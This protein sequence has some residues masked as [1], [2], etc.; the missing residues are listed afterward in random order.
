MGYWKTVTEHWGK[1]MVD[2]ALNNF[3][4]IILLGQSDRHC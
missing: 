4:F 2:S 1:Y 3:I